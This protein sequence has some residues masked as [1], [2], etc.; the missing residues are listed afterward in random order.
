[1]AGPEFGPI[2]REFARA[3]VAEKFGIQERFVLAVG[4]LQPRKNLPVL[5]DA[6]AIARKRAGIPHSLVV[7]GKKGWGCEDLFRQAARNGING[8][9]KYTDYVADEDLPALYSACDA[10]AYPSLSEGFGLPPLEA[11]AC[12]APVLVSDAPA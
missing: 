2:P 5:L 3:V 8:A 10:M 4:V 11:M 7:T 12:G 1:A 9:L 6:F